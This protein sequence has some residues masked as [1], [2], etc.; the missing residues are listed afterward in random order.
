MKRF[1]R[2]LFNIA[3]LLSLLLFVAMAALWVTSYWKTQFVGWSDPRQFV[4][5]LSMTGLLRF[6]HGTYAAEPGFSYVSYATPKGGLR[7]EVQARDRSGGMFRAIGFASSS[8]DYNFDGK[9][10]RRSVYV[11][12]WA[13]A[14]LFVLLPAIRLR[15]LLR[16]RPR[17]PEVCAACGYDLRATPH[18][19]PECGA[20]PASLPL[21]QVEQH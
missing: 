18:R 5:A 4:G 13:L 1:F 15:A 21:R 2:R 12:H 11:P 7:S 14:G 10:M 3:S 9:N 20:V 16:R 6:E 19:C 17:P 8:I